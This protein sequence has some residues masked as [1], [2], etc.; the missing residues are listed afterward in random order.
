MP[1]FDRAGAERRVLGWVEDDGVE[2][3]SVPLCAVSALVAFLLLGQTPGTHKLEEEKFILAQFAWRFRSTVGSPREVGPAE[4]S[5]LGPD[6]QGEKRG[7]PA[8]PQDPSPPASLT[9]QSE[10]LVAQPGAECHTPPVLPVRVRGTQMPAITVGESQQTLPPCGT[11]RCPGS[12]SALRPPSGA[13]AL[14]G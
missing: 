12:G 9:P 6:R 10:P 2:A 3:S 7:P 14:S 5:S 1:V 11:Q 8:T 4:G 13:W